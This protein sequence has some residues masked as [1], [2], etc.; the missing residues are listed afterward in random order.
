MRCAPCGRKL[1]ILSR[2]RPKGKTVRLRLTN[3][4]LFEKSL[5]KNFY[6][7][8]ASRLRPC[9]RQEGGLSCP[10]TGKLYAASRLR[11]L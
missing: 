5:T 2:L 6:A 7:P 1:Y 9:R 10:A 8:T 3:R 11:F 4:K